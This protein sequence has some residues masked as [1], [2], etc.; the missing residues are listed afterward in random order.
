M[1][2][3]SLKTASACLIILLFCGFPATDLFASSIEIAPDYK[4]RPADLFLNVDNSK[5]HLEHPEIA[6]INYLNLF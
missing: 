3:F 5:Q 4:V 2:F 6:E 1:R